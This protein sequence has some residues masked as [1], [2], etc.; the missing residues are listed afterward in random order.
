MIETLLSIPDFE[1]LPVLDVQVLH[2]GQEH[3]ILKI[4]IKPVNFCHERTL[5]V[6]CTQVRWG[7][8][9]VQIEQT[10]TLFSTMRICVP[11]RFFNPEAGTYF[12]SSYVDGVA[13]IVCI[14][15]ENWQELAGDRP[16][17][18][19]KIIRGEVNNFQKETI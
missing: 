5:K 9:Y 17:R 18:E 6:S 12:I 4:W 16:V 11:N 7:D 3:R 2:D 15:K 13:V 1:H 19:G 10:K 14:A 8:A